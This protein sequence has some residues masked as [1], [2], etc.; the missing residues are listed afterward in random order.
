MEHV[1]INLEIA[2]IEFP[3]YSIQVNSKGIAIPLG[4]PYVMG[5]DYLEWCWIGEIIE[6]EGIN[7]KRDTN[8]WEAYR[9]VDDP[10]SFWIQFAK[11]ETPTKAAALCYLKMKGVKI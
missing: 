4:H 10:S 7:L 3:D 6:R 9:H 5:I 8:H 11:A 2:K 1:K